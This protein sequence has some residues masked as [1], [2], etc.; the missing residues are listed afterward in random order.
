MIAKTSIGASFGSALEYGA[1]LKPGKEHKLSE[2]L[3]AS[4]LA[5][6]DPLNMAAEMMAVAD[7]SR[8][9]RPVWHTSLN[10][11]QGEDVKREQLLRAAAEYCRQMGADPTR[12]QVAIYQHHDRPHTHIHIYINR[13]PID[14]GAAL[15]TSHNYA[16][17]V[18]VCQAITL[19]LGMSQV[20]QQRQSLKDHDAYKQ[21]SREYVQAELKMALSDMSITTH[22]QLRLRLL[23]RGIESQF[24]QD[25]QNRLVGCSFRYEQMAMK[26]SEVG[27]K[28]QQITQHLGLN[29]QQQ[30][31]S[32]QAWDALFVG[33]T[34]AKEQDQWQT[35]SQGYQQKKELEKQQNVPKKAIKPELDEKPQR[36]LKLGPRR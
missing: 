27:H 21:T 13:V 23:E 17:N 28:A 30:Q 2:L 7:S 33:Y 24:K 22:E 11:P 19:Q 32:Q 4:N 9:Q 26:G 14:G 12:H 34:T 6:R 8:C 35:L 10:W 5:A 29:Q 20:P 1:G 18:K 16:R 3:G 15:D 31:Q 36:K 25:S